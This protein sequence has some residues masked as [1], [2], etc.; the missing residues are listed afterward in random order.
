[1]RRT[2]WLVLDIVVEHEDQLNSNH[3][4]MRRN[5]QNIQSPL[6]DAVNIEHS[7]LNIDFRGAP[8]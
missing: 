5:I 3:I 7:R 4:S 2:D 6:V 8:L 1:M